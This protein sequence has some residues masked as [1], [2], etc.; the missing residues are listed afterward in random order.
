VTETW[1]AHQRH[2]EHGQE[3][4][5]FGKWDIISRLE[6]MPPKAVPMSMPA[7]PKKRAMAKSATRAMTSAVADSGRSVDRM[8]MIPLAMT[9][10]PKTR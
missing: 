6:P 8:G 4:G 5:R 7:T 3:H 1:T 10:T 2:G 9:E